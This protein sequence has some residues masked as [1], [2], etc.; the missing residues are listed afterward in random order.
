[1]AGKD[2]EPLTS[3]GDST[4]ANGDEQVP[5]DQCVQIPTRTEGAQDGEMH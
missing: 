4:I 5:L 1:M 3:G 2:C